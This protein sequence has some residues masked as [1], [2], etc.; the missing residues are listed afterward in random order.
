[1]P[2]GDAR[3]D[4]ASPYSTGG[5][6]VVLEHRFGAVLLTHL[7]TGHP[8]PALGDDLAPRSVYLQANAISPV[9]DVV[10]EGLAPNGERRRLS[11]GVR[12]A[13]ALTKKDTQ[14]ARL[15]ESYLKVIVDH[16]D[17][18]R[19][20]RWRLCLAVATSSNAVQQLGTLIEIARTAPSEKAFRVALARPRRTNQQVRDRMVSFDALVTTAVTKAKI[21][22]DPADLAWR[23]LSVLSV[24]RLFLEGHD[25]QD[26]TD[27]VTR[28][29]PVVRDGLV[30]TADRLFARLEELVGGY[31]PASAELEEWMVRRDL[32]GWE[33][34]S[35]PRS[36]QA[37]RVL[38]GIE[39]RVR[40]DTHVY[41]AGGARRLELD[42]ARERDA[43]AAAMLAAGEGPG[44]LVVTGEPDVGKSALALQAADQLAA[45]GAAVTV[46]APEQLPPTI[47]ELE[48]LLGGPLEEVLG[49]T[50]VGSARLLLVDG[51]EAVQEG[52]G[53]QFTGLAAAA[54]RVGLGVVAVARS[55]AA[56]AVQ[57]R[58]DQALTA[59]DASAGRSDQYLVPA[60]D[61][62]EI[63]EIVQ[64]FE[65][66]GRLAAEPR[67]VWLLIRPGLLDLVLRSA[68]GFDLPEGPLSEADVFAVVWRNLVRRREESD[69]G[70]TPDA[71]ARAL[72]TLARRRLDPVSGAAP[73]PA[74]LPSLRSDGLVAPADPMP[75]WGAASWEGGGNGGGF[76][77][78]LVRD[79][80]TAH[81][82]LEERLLPLE[83]AAA[84]RWALRAARLT[85]QLVLTRPDWKQ[86]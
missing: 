57:E 61:A 49:G 47:A 75:G 12:R 77:S 11:V 29:R 18:V 27:A 19:E 25:L 71:R 17:E 41:L 51:A 35:S 68:S 20:G 54:L 81:L 32:S 4:T 59:V 45:A 8:V 48:N 80:A 14:S 69:G 82:L 52:R 16:G 55:D 43:L 60:L 34:A 64:A 70:V 37:W 53:P 58:L 40:E 74:V 86:R 15:L 83:Q 21:A 38:G 31:A 79:F 76:A 39:Q 66:L 44:V 65:S 85:C 73:D 23:L 10:V 72:L 26:R 46:L 36:P 1:M 33:L 67:A 2:G 50:A 13:P 78:D 22:G 56:G 6:G 42:R 9:D 28:L 24:W 63:G 62:A 7:L 5:G 84:P 30:E 3:G